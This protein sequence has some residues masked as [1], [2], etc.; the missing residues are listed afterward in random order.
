MSK[1]KIKTIKVFTGTEITMATP[2]HP[3]SVVLQLKRIVDRISASSDTEFEY[4]CNTPEG[5]E[6]FERYGRGV[7]GLNVIY[8]INGSKSNYD[9]V[10]NDMAKAS[11]LI[12]ETINNAKK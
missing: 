4:N 3:V 9:E 11:L 6:M 5:I 12:D 2:S 1:Q 7:H 8:F 10:M